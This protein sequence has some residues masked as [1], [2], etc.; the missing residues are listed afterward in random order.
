MNDLAINISRESIHVFV[1]K[2]IE[3]MGVPFG[4]IHDDSS[5]LDLGLDSLDVVELS[6]GIKKQLLIPVSPADFADVK[7]VVDAVGL[8]ASRAGLQ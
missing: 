2:M 5:L 3:S 4:D 7:T 1:R 8:V 6:Q